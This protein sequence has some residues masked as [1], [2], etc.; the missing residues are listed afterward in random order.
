VLSPLDALETAEA[1]STWESS[2]SSVTISAN[3]VGIDW[4][5][6]W[7]FLTGGSSNG[8]IGGGSAEALDTRGRGDLIHWGMTDSELAKSRRSR[9]GRT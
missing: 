1:T 5:S 4:F 8:L 2:S 3:R 9:S 6:S 7:R